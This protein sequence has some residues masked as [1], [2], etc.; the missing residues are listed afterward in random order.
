MHCPK[1]S[2]SVY[3]VDWCKQSLW[4]KLVVTFMYY[5]MKLVLACFLIG[6]FLYQKIHALIFW[7]L[8]IS[9][10][11]V[12]FLLAKSQVNETNKKIFR[13]VI[14]YRGHVHILLSFYERILWTFT[15]LM[16][17]FWKFKQRFTSFSHIFYVLSLLTLSKEN[18]AR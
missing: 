3:T 16:F 9:V 11:L 5:C 15:T 13:E 12:S 8:V 17:R 7:S 10:F 2:P 18:A 1:F 4:M 6:V 14:F